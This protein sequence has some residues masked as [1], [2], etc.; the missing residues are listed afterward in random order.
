MKRLTLA[1]GGLA[2]LC[3][4]GGPASAER[5]SILTKAY[6]PNTLKQQCLSDGGS[7]FHNSG[8]YGCN[9]PCKNSEGGSDTC[10]V[11]CTGKTC[12]GIT[13]D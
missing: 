1:L 12:K 3:L 5:T 7:Y 8:A 6:T 10:T 9:K 13:P 2:A 4:L 11:T